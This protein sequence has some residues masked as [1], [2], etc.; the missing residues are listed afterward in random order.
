[1][2]LKNKK[3]PVKVCELEAALAG[4]QIDAVE[5]NARDFAKLHKMGD[6]QIQ[7][8]IQRVSM[9]FTDGEL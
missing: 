3:V 2:I 6:V 9:R 7:M 1:M 5:L 4:I 8:W